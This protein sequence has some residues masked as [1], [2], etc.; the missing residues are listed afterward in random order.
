MVTST[1]RNST[2]SLKGNTSRKVAKSKLVKVRTATKRKS[3]PKVTEGLRAQIFRQGRD[4][5]SSVYDSASKAGSRAS[6]ALPDFR[7]NL[8][9]RERSQSL[10]TTMEEHPFVIGAVGLGVGMVLAALLPSA[11]TTRRKR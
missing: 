1:M 10:Y 9:V 7:S 8:K 6:R 5:A 11:N 2:E 3:K 4:A